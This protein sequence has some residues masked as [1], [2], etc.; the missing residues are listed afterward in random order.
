MSNSV[1]HF[2]KRTL[3]LFSLMTGR[4]SSIPWVYLQ[5][6]LVSSGLCN[7]CSC[8]YHTW[9][10]KYSLILIEHFL[11]VRQYSNCQGDNLCHAPMISRKDCLK[12]SGLLGVSLSIKHLP[13]AQIMISDPG[14]EPQAG[15]LLLLLLLPLPLP[16]FV[17]S[18]SLSSK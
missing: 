6:L 17:F 1:S 7:F 13:S 15:A 5:L 3:N 18:L 9:L 11:G 10:I 12:I 8:V 16:L 2:L 4:N 14:M